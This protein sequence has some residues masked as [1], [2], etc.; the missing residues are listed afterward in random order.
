MTAL[1]DT[2]HLVAPTKPYLR[3]GYRPEAELRDQ[4]NTADAGLR[5][6]RLPLLAR[7]VGTG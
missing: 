4:K 2:G 5:F 3:G 7:A 1:T 6:V